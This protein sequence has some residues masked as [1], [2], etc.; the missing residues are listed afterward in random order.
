M[1]VEGKLATPD[2]LT[3]SLEA[4]RPPVPLT[5]HADYPHPYPD[6]EANLISSAEERVIKAALER[7][8]ELSERFDSHAISEELIGF[9]SS[10]DLKAFRTRHFND[11][12]VRL[13]SGAPLLLYF[14]AKGRESL[15]RMKRVSAPHR[16]E[17][18]YRRPPQA[19]RRTEELPVGGIA[20]RLERGEAIIVDEGVLINLPAAEAKA[21]KSSIKR[22][23]KTDKT[24][25]KKAI[26]VARILHVPISVGR[27]IVEGEA[28]RFFS[29]L[30]GKEPPGNSPQET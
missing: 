9:L 24:V 12:F 30:P 25:E 8:P 28:A 23:L 7:I 13:Q 3:P 11:V 21:A 29:Q 1:I 17:Q 6:P 10:H 22:I 27:R 26:A 14:D 20:E 5:T 2:E 4:F 18:L 16:S 19:A 15:L